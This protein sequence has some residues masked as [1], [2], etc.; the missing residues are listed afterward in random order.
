MK[1]KFHLYF[2][3]VF[4][5]GAFALLGLASCEKDDDVSFDPEVILAS[6]SLEVPNGNSE[7][8][9]DVLTNSAWEVGSSVDWITFS[10]TSGEKGRFDLIFSVA[11]NEDDERTGII[12]IHAGSEISKEFT[13]IQEAGNRDDIYVIPGGTGEG[14]TWAEATNLNNALQIAVSGNTVHI[15][16]GTYVPTTTVTGGDPADERDLTFEINK[17][18]SLKGGYPADASEGATADASVYKTILSGNDASYH[19]VTVS[20]SKAEAQKV[21]LEG[22]I[23]SNGKASSE[24]SSAEVNGIAFRRDYGGGVTIGN[25]I[26]DI[27]NTEIVN[28][29]SEKN[30]A[31]LYAFGGSVVTIK[32][33]KVNNNISE[34]NAGGVWISEST[35]YISDSEFIGNE[36]GT[37]AGVHGYPDSK[38]Y[39][40][41]S[42]IANNKGRSYGAAFYIRQNSLGILVNCIISGNTSTSKN[43]GGGVMMYN[44]NHVTLVSTTIT[45]NS[46]A[47]PGA[48]VYRR[49]GVNT[50]E[51]YNSIIT[52]N[53]SVNDGPDVDVYESDAPAPV[54]KNSILGSV[55]YDENGTEVPETVFN[56]IS[57]L[58]SSGEFVVLPVGEENPAEVFGMAAEGLIEL[59]AGLDP[60]VGEEIMAFDLLF[61][62]RAGLT[63]MGA[64]VDGE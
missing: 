53:E 58:E 20:A 56:F 19:V 62:S 10:E 17:N 21:V 23:V 47:G 34:G 9:I 2:T 15:A 31:G 64:Y 4:C 36:G 40:N 13:V 32:D 38:I 22:L 50:I 35:A 7:Q 48:G 54:V 24:G 60:V 1:T 59:G 30:V 43:G 55:V 57:M 39:M 44:N 6:E 28:N 37:A 16:E 14:Y 12:T 33:S 42:I 41:N 5:L 52:G 29:A 49:S 61:N 51:I 27:V 18:I 8:S 45:G 11:E 26:V 63:T 46:I 3:R 25:A